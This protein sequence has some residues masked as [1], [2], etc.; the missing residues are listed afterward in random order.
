MTRRFVLPLLAAV[1]T[2]AACEQTADPGSLDT[3]EEQVAY[4]VGHDLGSTLNSQ[5]EQLD[6]QNVELDNDLI[7]AAVRD[8]LNGDSLLFSEAEVDSLMRAFQDTLVARQSFSNLQESEAF[9][10]ETA[11]LDSVQATESGLLYKVIETGDGASPEI[12]DTVVVNYRGTLPDGTEF[13]SSFQRGQPAQFVV[14]EVIP[15]WNEA[16]QLMQVGAQYELYIPADL[17]YGEQAPPQIGPNRAL[18]FEVELLD[19]MPGPDGQ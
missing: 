7:V 1:F 15:G 2:L 11:A 14:G 13:D 3:L 6:A 16:L 5:M 10:T 19:V 12:G 17:A 8:G 9:L 4:I 18:I